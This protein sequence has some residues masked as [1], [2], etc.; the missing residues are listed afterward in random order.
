MGAMA[1]RKNAIVPGLMLWM[2]FAPGCSW[3]RTVGEYYSSSQ[4]YEDLGDA[5]AITLGLGLIAAVGIGI[6]ILGSQ[7]GVDLSGLRFSQEYS[8]GGH[9][10]GYSYSDYHRTMSR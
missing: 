8:G 2:I 9:R 1:H 5:A 10:S 4:W 7:D 3:Y 6:L